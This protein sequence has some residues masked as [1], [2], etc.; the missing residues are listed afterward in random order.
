MVRVTPA[1]N[2]KS[3]P[4]VI[5]RSAR[6][7]MVT[8]LATVKFAAERVSAKSVRFKVVIDRFSLARVVL[9]PRVR[10]E[11]DVTVAAFKS[12]VPPPVKTKVDPVISKVPLVI[13][14][15][16]GKVTVPPLLVI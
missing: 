7:S 9:P 4:A 10:V 15:A 3:L 1:V 14:V 5:I 6:S 11:G 13:V 16:A 2:V 12:K 8:V